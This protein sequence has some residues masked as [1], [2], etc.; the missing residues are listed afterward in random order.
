M[1]SG[2]GDDHGHGG[3]SGYAVAALGIF[4]LMYVAGMMG[5]PAVDK[6]IVHR[7]VAGPGY[8]EALPARG[9]SDAAV[10]IHEVADFKCRYCMLRT[11]L[12]KRLLGEHRDVQFVFKHFPFVSPVSSE[13]AAVAA[14]AA[15]RQGKFFEYADL[16][17][18][19]QSDRW[20]KD[21]LIG[22]ATTLGLDTKR[23]AEDLRDPA[24]RV[25][26]R[27]DKAAAESLEVRATPTLFINGVKVPNNATPAEIREMILAA[28]RQVKGILAGPEASNVWEAR[29]R[30][31]AINHPSGES[32]ARLY[33]RNDVEDLN[34]TLGVPFDNVE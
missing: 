8:S 18:L 21:Q 33:M 20:T 4:I 25:Y 19:N 12:I 14:M 23:F 3:A 22:Y 1:G 32:F 10:V 16:L 5:R 15:N 26:V 28:K 29:E 31:A 2:H 6:P 17:F 30:A 9:P 27:K 13:K 34:V 7:G 11:G 24:L